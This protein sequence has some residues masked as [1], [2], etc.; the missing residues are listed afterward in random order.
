MQAFHATMHTD[1]YISIDW[2]VRNDGS[3]RIRNGEFIIQLA[4]C[5]YNKLW[6]RPN[7][8][9][10]R[11]RKLQRCDSSLNSFIN[12]SILQSSIN[13]STHLYTSQPYI[14]NGDPS[15]L[16]SLQCIFTNHKLHCLKIQLSHHC[17]SSIE[18]IRISQA[19]AGIS[20]QC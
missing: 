20:H 3:Y 19:T 2:V 15:I 13:Q 8:R 18:C 16:P 11:S 9:T 12:D 17:T 6:R 1:H 10:C 7:S 5:P 14:P 4:L